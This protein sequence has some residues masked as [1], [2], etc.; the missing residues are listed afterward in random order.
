MIE[1]ITPAENK[2]NDNIG[3]KVT[4]QNGN[5]LLIGKACIEIFATEDEYA[6]TMRDSKI[7]SKD[8][9]EQRALQ[10]IN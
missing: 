4:L 6:T 9:I 2:N 5:I 7:I 8:S 1:T 10:Y 3:D